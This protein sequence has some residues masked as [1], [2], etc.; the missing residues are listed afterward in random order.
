MWQHD[1][2]SNFLRGE[3]QM[4]AFRDTLSLCELM[5]LGFSGALFTYDNR[6]IRVQNVRV[7]MDGSCADMAWHDMFPMILVKHL[8]FTKM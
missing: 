2:F 7:H 5:D 4:L 1:H 6:R 3:A 8:T